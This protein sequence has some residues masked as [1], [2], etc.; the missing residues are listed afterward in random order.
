MNRIITAL[1]R[2]TISRI[3]GGDI[4]WRGD[5]DEGKLLYKAVGSSAPAADHRHECIF[6]PY[7]SLLNG[8]ANTSLSLSLSQRLA[9]SRRVSGRVY[10]I[11][12]R[13]EHGP[14]HGGPSTCHEA[15]H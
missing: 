12:A 11:T 9:R 10:V 14:S 8:T 7:R 5:G 15:T 13:R 2:A 6:L 4:H 3:T 1:A